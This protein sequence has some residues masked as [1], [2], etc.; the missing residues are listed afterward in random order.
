METLHVIHLKH[1][2]YGSLRHPDAIFTQLLQYSL[3]EKRKK[4]YISISALV[5]RAYVVSY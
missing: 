3:N 4:V 5:Q 1:V 2:P